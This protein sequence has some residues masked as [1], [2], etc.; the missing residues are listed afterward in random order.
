MVEVPSSANV[1]NLKMLLAADFP[2]I[3]VN[4]VT[5]S[6]SSLLRSHQRIFEHPNAILIISGVRTSQVDRFT[7]TLLDSQL[8][9]TKKT[10]TV[11]YMD[12]SRALSSLQTYK[13]DSSSLSS[14]VTYQNGSLISGV[15]DLSKAIRSRLD[16]IKSITGSMSSFAVR[17]YT[18]MSI[19]Q[20]SLHASRDVLHDAER[21]TEQ[22]RQSISELMFRIQELRAKS[23][24]EILGS[25][26]GLDVVGATTKDDVSQALDKAKRDMKIVMDSL[27]WWN[28]FW[29]VDE[30]T[31]IVCNAVDKAW[32][33]DLEQKV[34]A[35]IFYRNTQ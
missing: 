35:L 34:G 27:K 20:R 12:P 21:E 25:F 6:L 1:E 4:P 14:I 16:E 3:V 33:K 11:L 2:V 17:S 15:N 7:Q 30:I 5:M 24:K 23:S 32:C 19:L 10:P 18:A 26:D 28:L 9:L 8:K 29:R 22:L 31:D 13:A